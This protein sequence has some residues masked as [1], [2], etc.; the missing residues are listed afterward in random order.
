MRE[1]LLVIGRLCP[2]RSEGGSGELD[3]VGG[4]FRTRDANRAP[5]R[6]TLW[7]SFKLRGMDHDSR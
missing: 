5:V 7:K 3:V 4:G 1:H 6:T 2:D